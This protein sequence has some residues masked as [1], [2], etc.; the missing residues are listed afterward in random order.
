MSP[1]ARASIPVR[2][3]ARVARVLE[4]DAPGGTIEFTVDAGSSGDRSI[5]LEHHPPGWTRGADYSAA[6][7][8]AREYLVSCGYEVEVYGS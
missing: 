7:E 2:F 8:A 1:Q 4:C 5:C 3:S 6:F